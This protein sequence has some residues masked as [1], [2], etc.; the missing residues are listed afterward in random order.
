MPKFKITTSDRDGKAWKGVGTNPKTGN[1]MTIHGGSEKHR[2]KWGTQGGKSEEQVK[3]F[4]ARHGKPE[5]P[6]QYVNKLNWE[7]GSQIGK[8]VNIPPKYFK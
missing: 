1:K 7:K 3:S 5:S 2:G 4:K 8:E 6:T